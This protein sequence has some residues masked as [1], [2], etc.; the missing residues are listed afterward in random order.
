MCSNS[1]EMQFSDGGLLSRA[2]AY[3]FILK[4]LQKHP[5]SQGGTFKRKFTDPKGF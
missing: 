3:R 4:A 5:F 2:S 1:Q